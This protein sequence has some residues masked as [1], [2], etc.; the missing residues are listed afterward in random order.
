MDLASSTVWSSDS[1]PFR[2][3]ASD[4]PSNPFGL[5]DA[6]P[7]RLA[8]DTGY[9][10]LVQVPDPAVLR[11][12]DTAYAHGS[13]LGTAMDDSPLGTAYLDDFMAFLKPLLS[14]TGET[15]RALEI[16]AGRGYLL[17]RLTDLGIDAVGLEP[18]GS[19]AAHWSRY[20]VRVIRDRFPSPQVDG[21]FD[22]IIAHAVLEH[23]A[24]AHAFLAAAH[25]RLRPGGRLLIT[26]PDCAGP[27]ALGDPSILL[28]EHF[29]YFTAAGLGRLLAGAGFRVEAS[30]PSWHGGAMHVAASPGGTPAAPPPDADELGALASYGG[31]VRRMIGVFE[32][33]L[34]AVRDSGRSLGIFCAP[35][36]VPYLP[37]CLRPDGRLGVRLFDDDPELTGRH[38]PPFAEAV[39]DR[40]AL[41]DRPVDELWILSHSFGTTLRA[42]LAGTP[43]M[44]RTIVRTFSEILDDRADRTSGGD[45]D[46]T[47]SSDLPAD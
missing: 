36:A 28:H 43:G 14:A 11:A 35:R 10:G 42:A 22:L 5:P 3:G 44:E 33:R 45:A 9:G 12:L 32:R 15:P 27:I 23:I 24:D 38:F 19:H 6:L 18:G 26:V 41:L 20:G 2:I 16:G 34:R 7:F 8:L 40:A 17:R 29:H 31:R 30:R 46:Y 39:E 47:S 25:R 1:F 4:R 21:E 37:G 13:L